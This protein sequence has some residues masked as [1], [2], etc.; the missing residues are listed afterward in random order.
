[1]LLR[2]MTGFK[3]LLRGI[4]EHFSYIFLLTPLPLGNVITENVVFFS[5]KYVTLTI[6]I[7]I[8]HLEYSKSKTIT[9]LFISVI[10]LLL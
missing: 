3:L 5:C 10:Q 7:K 1:M 9:I 2:V 6:V 4:T 8:F